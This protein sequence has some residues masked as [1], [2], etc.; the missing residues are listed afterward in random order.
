[1]VAAPLNDVLGT[2]VIINSWD[3]VEWSI[4]QQMSENGETPNLISLGQ[5]HHMTDNQDCF[6]EL[7]GRTCPCMVTATKPQHATM[8]T[9]VLSDEHLVRAN[10]ENCSPPIPVGLTIYER[11]L[12]RH[13]NTKTA[14]IVTKPH[15][16]GAGSQVFL[17]IQSVVD[18]F[19]SGNYTQKKV[20][21]YVIQL[22]NLWL[23]DDF[24]IFLHFRNPD[25]VGHRFGVNSQEYHDQIIE[26]DI[27]LGRLL[28]AIGGRDVVLY[29][30]S[31]HGFGCPEIYNHKCSPNTFIV[32]N[33]PDIG[34][35]YMVDFAGY[36]LANFP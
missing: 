15:M 1:M 24:I 36:V 19:I 35:M 5:I 31:D 22:L 14:H 10:G 16:I 9:G 8:L 34:D 33:D 18:V 11:I 23:N 25:S 32:S 26:D 7:F 28:V 27:Q 13:P 2:Q 4:L 21:D 30:L 17:N 12:E 20:T 3:G 29:V 6:P